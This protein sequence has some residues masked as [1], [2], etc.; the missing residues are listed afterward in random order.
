LALSEIINVV[1]G[2]AGRLVLSLGGGTANCVG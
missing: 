1:N 2:L